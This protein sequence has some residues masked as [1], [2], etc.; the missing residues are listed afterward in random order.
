MTEHFCGEDKWRDDKDLNSSKCLIFIMNAEI[1]KRLVIEC[2]LKD[3][4]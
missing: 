1:K 4:N 3:S 2:T